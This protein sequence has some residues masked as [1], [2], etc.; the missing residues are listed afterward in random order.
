MIHVGEILLHARK[1]K[2]LTIE[3]AAKA[4]KIQVRYIQ[5]LE[6]GDYKNL[7]SSAYVQGFVRN[8][9]TFLGLPIKE[10]LAIF[11]RE[12]D[13]REYL[14][15][16]PESFTKSKRPL[17]GFRLGSVGI[18]ISLGLLLI[19]FYVLFQYRA[20]LF[21]PSLEIMQPAENAT[22]TTQ[23]VMVTGKTEEDATLTINDNPVY[24]EKDGSFKKEL[25]VFNG[26]TAIAVK[27]VNRFGRITMR[28]IHI[29]VLLKVQ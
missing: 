5:A 17:P 3:E 24:V 27:T 23:T 10:V 13:E 21:S 1:K 4:T 12:F 2:G 8:Y 29:Q 28:V 11:R 7:P 6:R 26:P 15:V 16:L 18:T 22:I 9:A 20:A 19:F 25:S 14:T